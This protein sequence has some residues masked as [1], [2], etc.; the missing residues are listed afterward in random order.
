MTYLRHPGSPAGTDPVPPKH[1]TIVQAICMVKSGIDKAIAKSAFNR[2]ENYKYATCDDIYAALTLRMGA[3]GLSIEPLEVEC[4][5][6]FEI[7][8]RERAIPHIR[9]VF[10]FVQ[11]TAEASWTHTTA[12]RTVVVPYRGP[13]SMQVA[14]SYADKAYLRALFK[15]PTGDIEVAEAMFDVDDGGP[16]VSA[17]AAKRNGIWEAAQAAVAEAEDLMSLAE[18]DTRFRSKIPAQWRDPFSDLVERRHH[19]IAAVMS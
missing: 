1:P 15:L 17:A 3:A 16:K 13:Q 14:Q 7:Q 10:Q 9:V 18:V 19:Q 4:S 11:S 8:G 6:I 12:R 2:Q 5:D